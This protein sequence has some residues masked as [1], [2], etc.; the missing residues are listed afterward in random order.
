MTPQEARRE[1][2]RVERM[3]AAEWA[4]HRRRVKAERGRDEEPEVLGQAIAFSD[5][6]V[7]AA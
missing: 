3:T 6:R 7:D 4:D 2:R 5:R 1:A